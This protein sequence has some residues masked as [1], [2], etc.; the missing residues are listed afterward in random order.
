M[1]YFPAQGV[2]SKM[3]PIFYLSPVQLDFCR[4]LLAGMMIPSISK[5]DAADIQKQVG[6]NS[7]FLHL[8]YFQLPMFLISFFYGKLY[9]L[10]NIKKEI[11]QED[12][13]FRHTFG[14]CTTTICLIY[15]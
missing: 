9:L 5:Q 2:K 6:D 15:F 7:R 11:N 14:D 3:M 1:L 13:L 4:R 8:I 10:S 12:S